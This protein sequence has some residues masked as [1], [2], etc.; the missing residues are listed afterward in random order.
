MG[1]L[2]WICS[3]GLGLA[4]ELLVGALLAVISVNKLEEINFIMCSRPWPLLRWGEVQV[5]V[6]V[7][8]ADGWLVLHA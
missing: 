7:A 3:S 1:P 4:G 6:V 2:R 5:V 8:L